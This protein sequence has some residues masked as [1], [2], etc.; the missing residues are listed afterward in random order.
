MRILLDE[1]LPIELRSEIADVLRLHL[2]DRLGGHALRLVAPGPCVEEN[3]GDWLG[4]GSVIVLRVAQQSEG[5]QKCANR[6]FH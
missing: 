4:G 1:S 3:P 6:I 2:A 5:N